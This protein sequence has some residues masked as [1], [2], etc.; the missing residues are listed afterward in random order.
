M[1]H[2]SIDGTLM[3]ARLQQQ[4]FGQDVYQDVTVRGADGN[5]VN[6]GRQMVS[7]TLRD[8][9]V[10][11]TAGRFYFYN[12]AGNKGVYAFRSPG[13]AV[14][15]AYPAVR[16]DMISLI[17]GILNFAM[18]AIWLFGEGELR[19]FHL[20][21]GLFSTVLGIVLLVER[22][23]ATRAA[24]TD[25]ADEQTRSGGARPAIART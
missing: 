17:L 16:L 15:L 6:L 7:A 21:F 18:A 24:M 2:H 8:L 20:F 23:A 4:A 1:A 3:V 5:Q 19:F 10:P 13:A 22:R 9:M 14:R 25:R 11:G 12:F